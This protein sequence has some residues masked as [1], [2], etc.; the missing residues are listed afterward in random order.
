MTEE[1]SLS[2]QT[3][4]MGRNTGKSRESHAKVVTTECCRANQIRFH[5]NVKH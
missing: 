3:L 2:G 5:C 1:F 4:I